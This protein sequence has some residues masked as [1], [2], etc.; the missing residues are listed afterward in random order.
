MQQTHM[1][2]TKKVIRILGNKIEGVGGEVT[3]VHTGTSFFL[4]SSP[5]L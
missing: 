2:M 3:K 1:M 4:T 5:E